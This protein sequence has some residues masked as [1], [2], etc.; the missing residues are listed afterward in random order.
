MRKF[1]KS[2]FAENEVV[3]SFAYNLRSKVTNPFFGT[4][5]VVWVIHN[6]RLFFTVF[7]FEDNTTLQTK[8]DF[9][10]KYLDGCCFFIG[11]M[12]SVGL[13]LLVMIVSFIFLA[14]SKWVSGLYQ[15]R[16]LPNIYRLT[17]NSKYKTFEEYEALDRSLNTLRAELKKEK[18]EKVIV[19]S[20]NSMLKIQIND[21]DKEYNSLFDASTK[22]SLEERLILL[23]DH[24]GD[25]KK[26]PTLLQGIKVLASGSNKL[27]K[28][29]SQV[30]LEKGILK[31]E[32]DGIGGHLSDKYIITDLG[33][34]YM[35]KLITDKIIDDPNW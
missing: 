30:F 8:T 19:E 27:S 21:K 22:V 29:I 34:A 9:I 32:E 10:A 7:N 26:H 15:D 14:F 5:I 18:E 23:E 33:K 17:S 6:W 1:L 16:V 2:I 13:A 20:E 35:E 31:N 24:F 11:L 12:K 28:E 4:L 3:D 25:F